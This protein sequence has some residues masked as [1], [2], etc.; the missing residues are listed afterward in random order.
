VREIKAGRVFVDFTSPSPAVK[1]G[2]TAQVK[3]KLG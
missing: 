1:P 3:I 2:L